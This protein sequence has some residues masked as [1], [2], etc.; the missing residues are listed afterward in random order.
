MLDL[1][2]STYQC[3]WYCNYFALLCLNAQLLLFEIPVFYVT[4]LQIYCGV[5]LHNASLLM[6]LLPFIFLHIDRK[7]VKHP[8]YLCLSHD[9]ESL[10]WQHDH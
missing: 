3:N 7:P 1:S 6:Y 2:S 9:D 8:H 5:R 10:N 4:P